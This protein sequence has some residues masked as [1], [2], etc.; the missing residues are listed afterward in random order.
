MT[1]DL[2]KHIQEVLGVLIQK[3]PEAMLCHYSWGRNPRFH[4]RFKTVYA[5]HHH[6]T[7]RKLQDLNKLELVELVRT[8]PEFIEKVE[9][10]H[11]EI[12]KERPAQEERARNAVQVL[13]DL[14]V[15]LRG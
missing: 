2:V 14:L 10:A 7:W 6:R 1:D 8:I 12:L 3:Y 13:T 11:A 9:K 5:E 15:K 4:W